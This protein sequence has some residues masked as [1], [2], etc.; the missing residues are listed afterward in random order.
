MF[1]SFFLFITLDGWLKRFLCMN[2][3]GEGLLGSVGCVVCEC[4]SMSKTN[5]RQVER[6]EQLRAMLELA[7]KELSRNNGDYTVHIVKEHFLAEFRMHSGSGNYASERY[8][9]DF[10]TLGWFESDQAGKGSVTFTIS[11]DK[12]FRDKANLWYGIIFPEPKT[13]PTKEPERTAKTG[14]IRK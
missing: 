1:T 8:F 2:K 5:V 9:A 3:T 12:S 14:K 10:V 6:K 4:I 11:T 13:E 7:C